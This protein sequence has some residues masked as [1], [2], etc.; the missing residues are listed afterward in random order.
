M[1]PRSPY[2][3][4]KAAADLLA[5]ACFET[6]GYPV[7]VTRCSNNYGPY[8]FPEKVLPLMISNALEGRPLP[9]YG[10]GLNVREWIHVDDHCRGLALVLD[11]GRPGRVYNIGSGAERTNIDLIKAMLAELARA[12]GRP[13]AEYEALITFVKDRPGHD[14]RYALDTSRLRTELGFEPRIPLDQGLALTVDWY[15]SN[16]PWCER[17]KSGA[18][19][20]YYENMYGRR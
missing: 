2:A 3:A 8:Q 1:A 16:R 14:R 4:S 19:R 12:A 11:R 9:V 10:D 13:A 6:Y 18:Y 5:L 17:I 7:I 15:L 20:E